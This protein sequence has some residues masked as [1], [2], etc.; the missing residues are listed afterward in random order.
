MAIAY[1]ATG[2]FVVSAFA[3]LLLTFLTDFAKIALANDNVR[4][5][6]KAET[7]ISGRV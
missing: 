3:I 7:W 4:P 1:V 2:K 6:R 5:S